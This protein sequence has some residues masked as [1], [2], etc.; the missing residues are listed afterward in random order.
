MCASR[1]KFTVL[2]ARAS[3][4]KAYPIV[5]SLKKAGYRVIVATDK[6][7][8]ELQFSI[9]PDKFVYVANPYVSEKLYIASVLR[10]V[11]ENSIDIVIPVGFIDFLLLSKYKDALEKY[12]IVPTDNYE[13][14]V[15]L[16]NKWYIKKLAESIGIN[17]P[18]TL[19]LKG[20]VD[21]SI[22]KTFIKDVG[23]PLV[24]KGLGDDSKPKFVSSL[25]DLLKEVDL[26]VNEGVLL[27]EFI[28]GDGVGYF[29]LSC[30]GQPMAEYIHRRIL[31]INP[32]GGASVKASS[33]FDP[34]P[35]LLGRKLIRE[36]KWTGVIMIEF[37]KDAESGAYYLIEINPKFWGSLEL[38]YR[39]GVDFPRYLVDFFLKG[40]KPKRVFI[41]DVY[42]SWVTSALSSYSRYGLRTV[43][44]II[45]KIL[46]KSPLLSDLHLHD[47]PNF[48]IKSITSL[49]SILKA[50]MNDKGIEHI[51]LTESFKE[52]LRNHR[53][54]LIV[55][56]L[57]GTLVKLCIPWKKVM[58]HARKECL[59]KPHKSI[60]ETLVQY[61][62]AR[63][64]VAFMKLSE[65][66][67]K[68]EIESV[69]KYGVHII[70]TT[71]NLP[72]LL[73]AIKERSIRFAIVSMQSRKAILECLNRLGIQDYVDAIV[74]R[75][76]TPIRSE[77]LIQV[78]R[79]L[80][81]IRC[82]IMLGDT[83]IDIKAAFKVG[84]IPCRIVADN[85]K[86]FQVKEMNVSY[87]DSV[88]SILKIIVSRLR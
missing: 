11:K 62:M 1:N 66:I 15:K 72:S 21:I 38:A 3:Y 88:P 48:M 43:L 28:V 67:E 9:F 77:A 34:E 22:I 84:L 55:S 52:A 35:L 14:I 19:S 27:Q 45:T 46:P 6:K 23:F 29:A 82:G 16:S 87:A 73:K 68:Y 33:N 57:D 71:N 7:G 61:Y 64:M 31:E 44:E 76:E 54:D 18:K 58:E 2:V 69:K 41:K 5:E 78:I 25:S 24:V 56:D 13:K 47:P 59:I 8:T 85:I 60:N 86:R 79:K 65:L 50:S 63:N 39:A 20:R 37:K 74:S 17:Y 10:A 51:Y 40:K 70:G 42:F 75:E 12:T 80:N 30:E 49:Y 36:V 26:R 4:S 32:L 53:L 81:G 83:L